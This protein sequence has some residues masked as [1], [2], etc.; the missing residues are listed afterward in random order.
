MIILFL[1]VEFLL[2]WRESSEYGVLFCPHKTC[3]LMW[4]EKQKTN[5]E[6]IWLIVMI[7][8]RLDISL[9][10]F[11]WQ[12]AQTIQIHLISPFTTLNYSKKTKSLENKL[13]T[14]S[15]DAMAQNSILKLCVMNIQVFFFFVIS[16]LLQTDSFVKY[17]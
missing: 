11:A 8:Y 7:E 12:Y 10:P 4:E 5:H 17:K 16:I 13:S 2:I 3:V 14:L 1:S 9:L 6:D 15:P